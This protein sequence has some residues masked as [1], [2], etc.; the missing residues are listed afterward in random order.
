[1]ELFSF[2][3]YSGFEQ[4]FEECVYT[5]IHIY[6]H[7]C[8]HMYMAEAGYVPL[9]FVEILLLKCI[10]CSVLCLYIPYYYFKLSTQL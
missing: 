1:M 10:V 4:C 6:T 7:T 5:L 8:T 3:P 9:L 2:I